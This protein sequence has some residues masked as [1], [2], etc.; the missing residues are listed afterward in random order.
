MTLSRGALRVSVGLWSWGALPPRPPK[1]EKRTQVLNCPPNRGRSSPLSSSLGTETC[2]RGAQSI[3]AGSV[4]KSRDR[5][6]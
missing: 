2:D 3:V 5:D 4:F 6:S 1:K